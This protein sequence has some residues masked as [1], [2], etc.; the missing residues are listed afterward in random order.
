MPRIG[1]VLLAVAALLWAPIALE[2]S[3]PAYIS[4]SIP[5]VNDLGKGQ[6]VNLTLELK[7]GDGT[8][9]IATYPIVGGMT[10]ISGT[11]AI[12]VATRMAGYDTNSCDALFK[13]GI[14][15]LETID[16]P[17]GGA[18][19]TLLILSALKNESFT[20]FTIT[21]TIEP[22]GAI[23]PVGGV[24]EKALAVSDAGIT[25]F[26]MPIQTFEERLILEAVSKKT[27]LAF[28]QVTNISQAEEVALG[29]LTNSSNPPL[30]A[31]P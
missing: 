13:I 20:K 28:F 8:A 14:G 7:H 12:A 2:C 18:A 19:M 31:E 10:Q 21:G 3:D 17:S 5:A 1:F 30:L 9:Y 29:I 25:L 4:M 26:I 24:S 15:E 16:G 6:M 11:T 23:G 22:N 27:G